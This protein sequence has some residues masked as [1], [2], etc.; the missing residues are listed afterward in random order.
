MSEAIQAR[1]MGDGAEFI[2]GVPARNLTESEYDAL[3]P[4]ERLAVHNTKMAGDKPL[5]QIRTEA[6]MHPA[7]AAGKDHDKD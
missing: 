4:D 6:E 5:Y 2:N 7:K 1:Y 3:T